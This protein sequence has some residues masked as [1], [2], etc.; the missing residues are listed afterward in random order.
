M[1]HFV[2]VRGEGPLHRMR[3]GRLLVHP[4]KATAF[5]HRDAKKIR[6]R[7]ALE[8]KD[9]RLYPADAEHIAWLQGGRR[10]GSDWVLP[11]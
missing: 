7:L 8:G 9:A 6:E 3:D 2:F 4:K 11:S 1:R 5:S 10:A